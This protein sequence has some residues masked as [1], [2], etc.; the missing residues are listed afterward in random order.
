MRDFD[1]EVFMLGLAAGA[2]GMIVLIAVM[3]PDG[4][5][6]EARTAIAVEKIAAECVVE[7]KGD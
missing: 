7:R 2:V 3:S 1:F 6:P 5:S 4:P